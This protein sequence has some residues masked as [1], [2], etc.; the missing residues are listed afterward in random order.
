MTGKQAYTLLKAKNPGVK[1][2]RCFEYDSLF[3]FHLAPDMLFLSKNHPRMLD[4][5]M[6]VNKKTGEIRDFKPFYVSVEEYRAG[7]EIPASAYKR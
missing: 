6:S 2:G 5:S 7:K 4:G 3:V 1:V